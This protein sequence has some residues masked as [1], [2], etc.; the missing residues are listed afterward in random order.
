M[1]L[2]RWWNVADRENRSIWRKAG[3]SDT[4]SPT[5]PTIFNLQIF[6]QKSRSPTFTGLQLNQG[7][8]VG[9]WGNR[10]LVFGRP[11]RM[12]LSDVTV[13]VKQSRYRP[14]VAQRFPGS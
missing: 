2:E 6:K 4:L 12:L 10:T 7:L 8:R 11:L 14:G 3:L 13:K 9:I 1:N 5:I